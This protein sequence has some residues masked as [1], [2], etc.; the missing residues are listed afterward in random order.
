MVRRESRPNTI[1]HITLG[2]KQTGA[3]SA[4]NLHAGCDVAGAG[5]GFTVWLLRHSQRKRGATARLDLRNTAPVLDP[6]GIQVVISK[7][8]EP[9]TNTVSMRVSRDEPITSGL[10]VTECLLE[11]TDRALYQMKRSGGG[12]VTA[13]VRF[14]TGL[15]GVPGHC[16]SIT[17]VPFSRSPHGG[18]W[19][20]RPPVDRC[21]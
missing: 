9:S 8:N 15:G 5:N 18:V 11:G 6:T 16:V 14:N 7:Q 2:T 21:E 12:A 3:P 20:V 10:P 17:R 19:S 1:S 4:G 13:P